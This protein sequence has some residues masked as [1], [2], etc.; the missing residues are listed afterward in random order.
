MVPQIGGESFEDFVA[1]DVVS[2]QFVSI[3]VISIDFIA[4]DLIS[5][6]RP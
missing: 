3:D 5:L 2:C 4:V 1:V 6:E